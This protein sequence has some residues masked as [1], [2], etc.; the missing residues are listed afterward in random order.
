MKPSPTLPP[1]MDVSRKRAKRT[2]WLFAGIALAIYV[3][4]ILSGVL[5]R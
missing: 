4:F 2:A 1:E 3:A 5:G